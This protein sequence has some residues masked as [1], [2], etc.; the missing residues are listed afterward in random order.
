M[1]HHSRLPSYLQVSVVSA[2]LVALSCRLT[3]NNFPLMV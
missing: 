1:L 3:S 2:A